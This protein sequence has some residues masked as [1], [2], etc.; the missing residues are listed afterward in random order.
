MDIAVCNA[1]ANVTLS[2]DGATFRSA[3]VAV[4]AVAP[5]PLFVQAAGD[6]LAGK[7]VS[8]ATMD[9]AAALAGEAARPITDMRG[10]SGQ[11]KHLARV[12]TRRVIATAVARAKGA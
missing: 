8:D 9:T 5:T 6:A 7:P 3:R 4:G 10:S 11:R 12:L 2:D 1:A